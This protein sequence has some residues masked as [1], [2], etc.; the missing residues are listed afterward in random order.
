MTQVGLIAPMSNAART[1][2]ARL[3]DSEYL[4]TS[5]VHPLSVLVALKVYEQGHGIRGKLKW[6]PVAGVVD[7]LDDAFYGAFGNVEPTGKQHILALDVSGSMA[8][9]TIAGMPITPREASAAMAMVTA[10]TEQEYAILAFQDRIVPIS[11]SPRQ[12]LDDVM[13]KISNLRFG[14]TDCA[15]P[16]LDAMRRGIRTDA[17]TIYT[18]NETWYGNV[19]PFQALQQYRGRIGVEAKLITVGMTSSGFTIADP[20]DGGMLDCVGFDTATPQV[21]SGFVKE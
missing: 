10:R 19:H 6:S 14:R 20:S 12:R 2:W 11:I 1:V 7:A 3:N 5:R 4:R 15:Q 13:R 16:M 21:I 9:G 8:M 18:D 17:F